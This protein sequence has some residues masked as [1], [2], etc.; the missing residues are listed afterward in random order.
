[1]DE[2][3]QRINELARKQREIG[4]SEEEKI[5]QAELRKK[6]LE[7]FRSSFVAQLENTYIVDETGKTKFTEYKKGKK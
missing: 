1:M 6:Y 3:L 4:L 7:R 2:L 5:E